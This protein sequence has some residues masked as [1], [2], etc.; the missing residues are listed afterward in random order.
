MCRRAWVAMHREHEQR[1]AA[2]AA[3]AEAEDG[4]TTAG[5]AGRQTAEGSGRSA[6]EGKEGGAIQDR[7]WDGIGVHGQR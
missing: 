5:R 1:E 3:E 7:R 2:A 6:G 4:G